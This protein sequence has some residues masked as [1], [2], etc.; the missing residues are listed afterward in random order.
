MEAVILELY[1]IM[2]FIKFAS[3]FDYKNSNGKSAMLVGCGYTDE[4]K[5][6]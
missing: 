2:V 6:R 4:L 1:I 3:I 5:Y